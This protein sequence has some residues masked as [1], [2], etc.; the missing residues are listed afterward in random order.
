MPIHSRLQTTFT[1]A[2]PARSIYNLS[3]IQDCLY[4]SGKNVFIAAFGSE[5]RF[6]HLTSAMIR[7]ALDLIAAEVFSYLGSS[8]VV[9]PASFNKWH[10]DTCNKFL[11]ELNGNLAASGYA[12]MHYGKAQKVLNMLMKY[13]YCCHDAPS[14][15]SKKKFNF[16][17]MAL[18]GYTYSGYKGK[19]PLAFYRDKVYPWTLGRNA[20]RNL[21]AWSNLDKPDYDT[22][23]QDIQD[24]FTANPRTFNDY[25]NACHSAGVFTHITPLSPADNRDL[26]PFEAEFFLWEICRHNH[27]P[28]LS[29]IY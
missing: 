18:D 28:A 3:D 1:L 16:C 17:H 11:I 2:N 4:G 23:V 8:T 19:Y 21:V 6:K 22:I 13:L 14:A 20:L 5:Q 10:G 15:F 25:L 12:P 7:P 29:A 24:F 27:V 26:T 9:T